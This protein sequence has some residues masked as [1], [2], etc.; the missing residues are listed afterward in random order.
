M[1][2]E[3]TI[4]DKIKEVVDASLSQEF[5]ELANSYEELIAQLEKDGISLTPS[6]PIPMGGALGAGI[7][8]WTSNLYELYRLKP[9]W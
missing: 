6:Y 8:V 2:L 4:T 9:S 5:I 1:A 7:N 3:E